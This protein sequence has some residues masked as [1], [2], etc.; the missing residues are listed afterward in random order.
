MGESTEVKAHNR[1]RYTTNAKTRATHHGPHTGR[2]GI[3]H[4]ANSSL[5]NGT[6]LIRIRSLA[7]IRC[8]DVYVPVFRPAPHIIAETMAEVELPVANDTRTGSGGGRNANAGADERSLF[9]L[10]FREP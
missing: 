2:K 1:K 10:D 8:G 6:M 7:S 4:L 3:T 9:D 5:D